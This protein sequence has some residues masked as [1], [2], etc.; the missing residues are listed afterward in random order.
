MM[1]DLNGFR[2]ENCKMV[3]QKQITQE[4]CESKHFDEIYI[5]YIQFKHM[6]AKK[7]CEILFILNAITVVIIIIMVIVIVRPRFRLNERSDKELE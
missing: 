2:L 7:M 5:V 3:K 6:D 1:N 4:F